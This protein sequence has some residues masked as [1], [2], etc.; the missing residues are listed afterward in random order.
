[1]DIVPAASSDH[2]GAARLT[3]ARGDRRPCIVGDCPG[4]MRY[5]RRSDQE[6]DADGG[7]GTGRDD[8]QGWVCERSLAH[9]TPDEAAVNAERQRTLPP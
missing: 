3:A 9:F 5:G 4:E 8:S 2:T 7:A 1:M 6:P